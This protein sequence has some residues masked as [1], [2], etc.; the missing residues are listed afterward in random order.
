MKM[1]TPR[2]HMTPSAIKEGKIMV[3]LRIIFP[4]SG[5]V[6]GIYWILNECCRINQKSIANRIY[7]DDVRIELDSDSFLN[8]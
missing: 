1:Q 7:E 8:C 4:D 6:P 2:G 5:T 3:F